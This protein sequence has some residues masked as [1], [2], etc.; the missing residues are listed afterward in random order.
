MKRL[1]DGA[2]QIT[3]QNHGFAVDLWSIAGRER[4]EADGLP[5]PELLPS[6]VATTFGEVSATHQ[7][8]N[9]G[10]NEGIACHDITAFSV[11][12]HPEAAPGPND[13]SVIFDRFVDIATGADARSS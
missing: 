13:A 12:Y 3:S 8:L 7:N 1:S 6:H 9:D 5:T 11:Q 2:V 10:T 4:P